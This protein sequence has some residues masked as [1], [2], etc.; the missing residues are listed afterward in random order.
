MIVLGIDPGKKGALV[1][2]D[3]PEVVY[4]SRTADLLVERDQGGTLY[5]PERIAEELAHCRGL[6]CRLAVLER[7]WP[8]PGEASSASHALGVGWGLW[9]GALAASGYAVIEPTPAAW[10]AMLLRD[11]PGEGK[12]RAILYASQCRSLELRRGRERKA[13]DG[14][15]D[16]YC[17]ADYGRITRA[18][19]GAA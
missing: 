16:A 11:L 15:A 8:R 2:L 12:A 14:L 3:G 5:V 9:R 1:L 17:L 18:A 13:H 4:Q 19:K 6:G 10:T 7:T